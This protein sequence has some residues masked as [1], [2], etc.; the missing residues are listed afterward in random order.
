VSLHPLL[1]SAAAG[2][3]PAWSRL[4]ERRREHAE[5]VAA[6]MGD[7][8]TS[9]GLPAAERDRWRAAGL[10]HD[11]LRDEDPDRLRALVP[12]ARELPDAIL[13]GPAAARLLR[14]EGVGDDPLLLAVGAHTFGHPDLDRMGLLLYAADWLEPGRADPAGER[15]AL[16]RRMPHEWEGVLPEV[17]AARIARLLR[18][19][20]PLAP[21]TVAFWNRVVAPDAP[22]EGEGHGGRA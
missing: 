5:R 9:L 4:S 16:R 2:T 1:S 8:A 12:D 14:D 6:L 17:A 19:R 18:R 15:A 7:W 22:A 20:R 13:H 21:E 11:V 3:F 10:L